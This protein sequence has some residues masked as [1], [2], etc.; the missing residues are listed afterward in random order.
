[1]LERNDAIAVIFAVIVAL[2]IVVAVAIGAA[3]AP[4]ARN[5]G[6]IPPC[7]EWTDGCTV[8][9]RTPQGLAC[10]TPGIACVAGRNRCLRP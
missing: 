5:E 7:S 2:V 8:C 1:M 10:S 4:V 9:S 3:F 6:P